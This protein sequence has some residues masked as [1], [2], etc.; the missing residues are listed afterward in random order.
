MST[1][2]ANDWQNHRPFFYSSSVVRST[3]LIYFR[4]HHFSV[5]IA[6]DPNI[7]FFYLFSLVNT[8]LQIK[9]KLDFENSMSRTAPV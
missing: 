2:V 8:S 4:T 3:D 1:T 9:F 6:N 7:G 5:G